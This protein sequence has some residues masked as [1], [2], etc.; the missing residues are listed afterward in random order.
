MNWS[1]IN[2]GKVKGKILPQVIFSDPDWFYWAVRKKIFKWKCADEARI[3]YKKSRSIK[4]PN[5]SNGALEAEYCTYEG[6]FVRLDIVPTS[7]KVHHGGCH[8]FQLDV[9]DMKKV[10]EICLYDKTGGRLLISKIKWIFFGDRKFR[11]TKNRCVEFFENDSNFV[12]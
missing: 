2:F 10:R 7:Q 6:K 1:A 11:M 4:I 3:I 5:S 9:I 8:C 12:I